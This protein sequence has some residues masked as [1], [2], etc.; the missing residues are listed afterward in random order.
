MDEKYSIQIN[1]YYEGEMLRTAA[2]VMCRWNGLHAA[3]Q[4]HMNVF[5][6]NDVFSCYTR[7]GFFAH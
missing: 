1:I 5:A 7:M 4:G 3:K 6:A 2:V